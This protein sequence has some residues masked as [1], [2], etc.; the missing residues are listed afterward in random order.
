MQRVKINGEVSEARIN[1]I[2]VPQG[3]I[4]GPILFTIYINDLKNALQYCQIKLFADDTLIYIKFKDPVVGATQL[5]CDLTKLYQKIYENRLKINI[6]KP[7]LILFNKSEAVDKNLIDVRID[8]KRLPL[9]KTV[10]YLGI[11]IDNELNFN[12]NCENVTKKYASKVGVLA[13][14]GD[15]LNLQQIIQIYKTTIEPHINYCSSILFLSNETAL[16]RLQK[17]RNMKSI[18][19]H[20][21][22]IRYI[23]LQVQSV[24]QKIVFNTL[25]TLYK[26]VKKIWPGYLSEKIKLK[27][28][29]E[30]KNTLRNRN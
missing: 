22:I 11:I 12:E 18:H 13:R 9:E 14:C 4:L 29:N 19:K 23:V 1:Q 26:I 24:K 6:S 15:R 28:E 16:D 3:S 27:S 7:K 2:G 25:I 21:C 10:K 30:R 20:S 8:D 5:N 17:I